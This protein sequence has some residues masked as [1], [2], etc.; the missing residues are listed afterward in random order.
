MCTICLGMLLGLPHLE[1][2]GWGCIYSPQYKTSHWRKAVAFCGTPDSPV[3]GTGQSG[4]P[5]RCPLAVGSIKWP[6]GCQPDGPVSHRTVRASSTMPPGTSRWAIVPW[7][8]GQSPCGNTILRFLEFAWYFLIFSCDIH[9]VFF[10]GVAFLN[11][12]VQ[13]TLASCE[14]QTKT[15]ANTLVHRL[16][17]SPNTKIYLAKWTGGLFSIHTT[18][19]NRRASSALGKTRL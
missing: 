9:N 1:M 5:I 7:C 8:T 3:V 11:A 14:L 15:L 19:R 2:A 6:L 17:W 18:R 10:W 16:C 12:L 4:A 13:V